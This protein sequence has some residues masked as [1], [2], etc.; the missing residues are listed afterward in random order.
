MGDDIYLQSLGFMVYGFEHLGG[1]WW[2]RL[3]CLTAHR[4]EYRMTLTHGSIHP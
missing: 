4:L 3:M 2:F 1:Q